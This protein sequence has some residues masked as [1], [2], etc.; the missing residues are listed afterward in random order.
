M[1]PVDYSALAEA[2][3]APTALIEAAVLAGCFGLAWLVV[4]V[5]RGAQ[6][7]PQSI[8]FG[9]RIIDGVLFPVLAL[10]LAYVAGRLLQ[11]VVPLAVFRV[12]VPILLSLVAI[13]VT[14]RVLRKA[15]PESRAMRVVERSVSWL[16]WIGVVLWI[17]GVL[18]LVLAEL[19]AIQWKL[20][21]SQVSLRNLIEGALSAVAVLVIALWV[22]A[23]IEARLLRKTT[24]D[25][26]VRKIAANAVRALLLFIGLMLAL[27]AAGIDLTALGVLGGAVGVGIGFGLQ[28]LASNYISGFVILAERSLHIGDLVKVDQFEGR[29]VDIKTRYT[30]I[31]ALNG[32]EANVPN[33]M[34]ITQRVE[35]YSR[36]DPNL[37]L[38]TSVQVKGATDLDA[39]RPS[40]LE[41]V[42]AVPR[43]LGKPAASLQLSAFTLEGLEL[44]VQFFIDD[45]GKGT[46]NVKSDVNEAVLRVFNAR[47]IRLAGPAGAAAPPAA[48]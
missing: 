36:A 29:V 26:S 10:V 35:N 30:V 25:L 46:G 24:G 44:T 2:L 32:R 9:K 13:R 48:G 18:P 16:V 34:L 47:G 3:V 28:K 42:S 12:A 40:L 17:T 27:S 4:R 1:A 15:F 7:R 41:A 31:R 45:P 23:A 39:L 38:T 43:V 33:E 22:S 5:V 19:D 20:G 8:W 37:A 6:P 21:D 11:E 14:V